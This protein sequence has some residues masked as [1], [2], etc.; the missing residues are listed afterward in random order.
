MVSSHLFETNWDRHQNKL[1]GRVA[2]QQVELLKLTKTNKQRKRKILTNKN[3]QS[4]KNK[5]LKKHLICLILAVP[6]LL[7]PKSSKWL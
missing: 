6:A 7:K 2:L 3:C 5:R 1:K 4:N